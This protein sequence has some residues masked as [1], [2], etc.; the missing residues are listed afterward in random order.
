M[1]EKK[2]MEPSDCVKFS[3][4]AGAPKNAW[5]WRGMNERDETDPITRKPLGRSLSN[6]FHM[7]QDDEYIEEKETE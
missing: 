2:D 3:E 6:G 5:F 1:I 7:M 4:G